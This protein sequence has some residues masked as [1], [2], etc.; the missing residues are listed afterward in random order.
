MRGKTG[1]LSLVELVIA[2]SIGAVLFLIAAQLMVAT[3]RLFTTLQAHALVQSTGQIAIGRFAEEL[4]LA[5]PTTL[6]VDDPNIGGAH[7][8]H[9]AISFRPQADNGIGMTRHFSPAPYFVIYF[10]DMARQ[11]WCRTTWDNTPQ[12]WQYPPPDPLTTNQRLAAADLKA[13]LSHLPSSTVK[14]LA[15]HVTMVQAYVTV[16]EQ[17]PQLTPLAVTMGSAAAHWT[18]WPQTVAFSN[19]P[20][21]QLTLIETYSYMNAGQDK[22]QSLGNQNFTATFET[23]VTPRNGP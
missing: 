11:A 12:T 18:K 4:R 10:Y 1:G 17:P 3:R 22:L 15:S 2:V 14:T 5:A 9:L 20:G 6:T 23:F 7:V 13:I 21:V 16:P 19:M 8:I